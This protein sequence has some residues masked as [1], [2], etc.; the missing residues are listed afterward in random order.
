MK[1]SIRKF[2]GKYA[3]QR[4]DPT[5]N[6]DFTSNG[7]EEKENKSKIQRTTRQDSSKI[8]EESDR[9]VDANNKNEVTVCSFCQCKIRTNVLRPNWKW[10]LQPNTYLCRDCYAK[11]GY[12]FER[13][14]NFCNSCNKKLGF[15]RYNPKP[16]WKM[17]GQ[18]C[19]N[20]WDSKNISL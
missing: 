9:V 11:K 13:R 14:I 16:K 2:I 10:N 6:L 1:V 20:C 18:M 19:K 5:N 17:T 3:R 7:L 8:G 12:E 4:T 15:I